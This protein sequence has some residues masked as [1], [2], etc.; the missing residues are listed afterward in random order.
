MRWADAVLQRFPTNMDRAGGDI[1]LRSNQLVENR[2]VTGNL[3]LQETF[4]EDE[5]RD[6]GDRS[7]GWG[8]KIAYPNDRVS[9]LLGASELQRGFNPALGFVNRTDIRRYD[10]SFRYRFRSGTRAI[11]TFDLQTTN[12][13]VT[14]HDDSVESVLV[15]FY[16]LRIANQRD[17][18]F[19]A[20]VFA[21]YEAVPRAFFL[22]P[23]LGGTP[24]GTYSTWGGY[25]ELFT[26]QARALRAEVRAGI[27]G[28]Y[29]SNATR[30]RVLVEWRPSAHW[31]ISAEYDERFILGLGA[32]RA[33]TAAAGICASSGGTDIV[34]S[35]DA[36]LRLARLRLQINFTPDLAWST[37]MQ[38]ENV[39]DGLSFQS[40]LR[41][42]LSPGREL[43]LVV[44]QDF[45]ASPDAFRV[46]RTRPA[47]KLSW[48]FRY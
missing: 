46:R 48:T 14:N 29:D 3:W 8:A 47:A 4:S 13:V 44:G 31:V 17:D 19:D 45:D 18:L 30:A 40:R 38:Y 43:I 10:G 32:C 23:Q 6:Y 41:W 20:Y 1:N 24:A 5:Q 42:I 21:S 26:S 12:S 34:R 28:L 36:A 9:R 39:S 7:T 15:G 37:I 11:R 22:A 2:V 27:G 16:P 35:T 25:L 33:E